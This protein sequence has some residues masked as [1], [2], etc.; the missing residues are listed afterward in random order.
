MS[1]LEPALIA[2][3]LTVDFV[4]GSSKITYQVI[5][6][7]VLIQAAVALQH[8]ASCTLMYIDVAVGS[9]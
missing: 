1:K 7:K 6:R 8:A 4:I 9:D 2:T 5:D 3:F